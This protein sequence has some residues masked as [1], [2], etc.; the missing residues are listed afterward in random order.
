MSVCR[1][2][3][4]RIFLVVIALLAFVPARIA[5]AQEQKSATPATAAAT[6]THNFARWEK[7]ISAYEAKDKTA[8]PARGGVVFTGSSTIRGWKTLAQ[9]YPQHN[10][11][12]R[13]FGGSQIV[14]ATHFADRIVTNYEP[15]MV[16]LRSGGND[17]N[18][19]KKAETVFKDFQNFVAAVHAKLPET[20][21]VFIGL[22]PAPVRWKERD[23]NKKLNDLVQ[24][25]AKTA[26]HVKYVETYNMT[27]NPDG[28]PR[29]ELFLKDRL[30]FNPEGYKL[31]SEHVRPFLPPKD[32]TK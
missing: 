7:E 31:L 6:K 14:D 2:P 13:G 5:S 32:A 23:E 18:A 4:P 27:V 16:F 29:E 12:N 19:G 22:S 25:W 9:D 15:K 17:I 28:T 26:P 30:H 21:V 11:I 10:V 3:L 20:D 8:P 1:Q 24:A